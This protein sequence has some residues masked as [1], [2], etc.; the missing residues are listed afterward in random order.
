MFRVKRHDPEYPK[1]DLY[2]TNNNE[3]GSKSEAMEFDTEHDADLMRDFQEEHSPYRHTGD[4][5]YTTE[6]D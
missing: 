2:L 1:D 5:T 4:Y 6:S 3:Y